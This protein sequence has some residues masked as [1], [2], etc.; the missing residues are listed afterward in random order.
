MSFPREFYVVVVDAPIAFARL[1]SHTWGEILFRSLLFP[2]PSRFASHRGMF[3]SLSCIIPVTCRISMLSLSVTLRMKISETSNAKTSVRPAEI[4]YSFVRIFIQIN[5]R[6]KETSRF[7][8]RIFLQLELIQTVRFADGKG[9]GGRTHAFS[10]TAFLDQESDVSR[11]VLLIN[12]VKIA[13]P[14]SGSIS[15]SEISNSTSGKSH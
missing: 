1:L 10:R 3:S 2:A 8:N 14:A 7:S 12:D 13:K 9:R 4:C 11:S 15:G 6:S 5:I